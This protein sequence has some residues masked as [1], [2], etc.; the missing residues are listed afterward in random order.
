MENEFEKKVRSTDRLLNTFTYG[1][2]PNF[3]DKRRK[4]ITETENIVKRIMRKNGTDNNGN[5][6]NIV[7]NIRRL[8]VNNTN[9]YSVKELKRSFDNQ[10]TTKSG[11][12]FITP[13]SQVPLENQIA[14][15]FGN[16]MRN[17]QMLAIEY[18]NIAKLVPEIQECAGL[19]CDTIIN[20]NSYDGKY[21]NNVYRPKLPDKNSEFTDAINTEIREK[22][23][24]KYDLES[25]I[26][27]YIKIS[28]I[29]A[30]KPV[31]IYSYRD[32]METIQNALNSP[33]EGSNINYNDGKYDMTDKQVKERI[34]ST[35][36]LEY[37]MDEHE[38]QNRLIPVNN[39]RYNILGE[40]DYENDTVSIESIVGEKLI[41]EMCERSLEDIRSIVTNSYHQKIA[42]LRVDDSTEVDIE[43]KTKEYDDIMARIEKA[44]KNKIRNF[45]KDE[46]YDLV[47][48]IDDNLKIYKGDYAGV[49]LAKAQLSKYF[50]MT[51]I[52]D[53]DTQ[54]V[55]GRNA[56][57]RVS[58]K[59]HDYSTDPVFDADGNRKTLNGS[60]SRRDLDG[61]DARKDVDMWKNEALIIPADMENVIPVIVNGTHIGYYIFEESAYT[62]SNE[63]SRKRHSSFTDIFR[64]L[65]FSNDEVLTNYSSYGGFNNL[66]GAD[67]LNLMAGN[68]IPTGTWSYNMV[69]GNYGD[70]FNTQNM[71]TM[72]DP[73]RRNEVMKEIVLKTISKKMAGMDL[74]SDKRF[75]D[76]IMN[77]LRDGLILN[78]QVVM[79][80]VPASHVCYFSPK[81]DA[82]GIPESLLK[83]ALWICYLYI[84]S[85]LGSAMIKLF[86][87]GTRDKIS[88]EVGEEKNIQQQIRV[89]EKALTSR[90]LNTESVY[91]S[92]PRVLKAS[93][94]T[95]TVYEPK[96]NGE[97]LFEYEDITRA[98]DISVDDSYTGEL[99]NRIIRSMGAPTTVVNVLNEE[100]FATTAISKNIVFEKRVNSYKTHFNRPVTKLLR[101]LIK[102][103]GL[104]LDPSKNDGKTT[105]FDIDEINFTFTKSQ[106]LNITN[107][108]NALNEAKTHT[109]TLASLF[110]SDNDS[111]ATSTVSK[112]LFKKE[113]MKE[114]VPNFDYEYYESIKTRCD[115]Q[116]KPIVSTSNVNRQNS[117]KI[118][119]EQINYGEDDDNEDMGY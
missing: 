33:R 59:E 114:L 41:D 24:E 98:N 7:T 106:D 73:A 53:T 86:K 49:N 116:A 20:K 71:S 112:E 62:G 67:Q 91:T 39:N 66:G 100:E 79:T 77:L 43:S 22:I 117:E 45:V 109:E 108:E 81:I 29:E 40:E 85:L 60:H 55:Y 102:I 68:G 87:S 105:R 74:S 78:K 11:A 113:V 90:H 56:N 38:K 70:M 82:D 5:V 110:Y 26:E 6:D 46:V 95:D 54:S 16:Y 8:I 84:S 63:A 83:D 9:R 107:T 57:T 111:S 1:M 52:N 23:V 92:L 80:Y 50:M 99:L 115:D 17:T 96:F 89:L 101:L 47:K 104:D 12:R 65:G 42:K 35:E 25:K 58:I 32:I 72:V 27:S 36:S 88:F 15:L 44:D 48:H 69:N 76:A 19:I 30:A 118:E 94:T 34:A 31:I 21:I 37:F 61:Y 28:L 3:I 4:E 18:R 75:S 64:Q 10:L 13:D 51:D 93:S 2:D 97:K 14:E 103:E 119:N